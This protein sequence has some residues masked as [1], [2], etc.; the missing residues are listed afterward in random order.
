[1]S[2]P[3]FIEEIK[4]LEGEYYNLEYHAIRMDRTL[5]HFF[6]KAFDHSSLRGFL[7]DPPKGKINKCTLIY[8]DAVLSAELRPYNLPT[9]KT[10]AI[11]NVDKIDFS[12]KLEDRSELKKIREFSGADEV[13]IARNGF[14]TNASTANLVFKDQD[15]VLHTPLHY[16]H[17]GTKRQYYLKRQLI[18]T[19][20]IK[21]SGIYSYNS[22]YLI[23]A[24]IDLEDEVGLSTECLSKM[25]NYVAKE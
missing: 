4:S 14:V 23:N 19:F 16:I 9:I 2:K 6:G 8:S 21:V 13:I 1:L 25:K 10:M 7:P 24:M 11:V 5:R 22:V 12:Y 3:I 17:S 20:P 15:G 18:T